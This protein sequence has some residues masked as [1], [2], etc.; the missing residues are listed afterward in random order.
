MAL[1]QDFLALFRAFLS[2]MFAITASAASISRFTERAARHTSSFVCCWGTRGCRSAI[3]RLLYCSAH[4]ALTLCFSATAV[5][6]TG[7]YVGLVTGR[8]IT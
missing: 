7:L 1:F 2:V 5:P 3:A 8:L 6:G 4:T